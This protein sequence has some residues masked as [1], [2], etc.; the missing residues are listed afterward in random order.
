MASAEGGS[1]P[2]GVGMVRG[3]PLSSRLEGLGERLE[4]PQRGSGQSPGRKRILAADR[5]TTFERSYIKSSVIL[6]KKSFRRLVYLRICAVERPPGGSEGWSLSQSAFIWCREDSTPHIT[7]VGQRL[8]PRAH[9]AWSESGTTD[10][11][12]VIDEACLTTFVTSLASNKRL[13]PLRCLAGPAPGSAESGLQTFLRP[14]PSPVASLG[15]GTA[16]EAPSGGCTS[17][18][19]TGAMVN[20]ALQAQ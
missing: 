7:S 3:V 10:N 12:T 18:G 19:T 11:Q 13:I 17:H 1:L 5:Q 2:N 8:S 9:L 15:R 20:P 4:L 6:A 16:T 14:T